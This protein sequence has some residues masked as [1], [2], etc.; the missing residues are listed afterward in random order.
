M[1]VDRIWGGN[2]ERR[3]DDR[4]KRFSSVTNWKQ[5]Q[6]DIQEEGMITQDTATMMYFVYVGGWVGG[7]V[8]VRER[9]THTQREVAVGLTDH[10]EEVDDELSMSPQ[11]EE[12]PATKVLVSV[13]AAA[14]LTAHHIHKVRGQYEGGPLPLEPLNIILR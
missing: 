6:R 1:P 8:S 12:G 10:R 14:V 11:G 4:V 3:R 13:K 7:W 2:G 9:D 5:E